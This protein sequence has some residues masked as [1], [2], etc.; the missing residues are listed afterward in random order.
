MVV[1]QK[2][3]APRADTGRA[4]DLYRRETVERIIESAE[5]ILKRVLGEATAREVL[6]KAQPQQQ[7][8]FTTIMNWLR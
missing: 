6:S 4:A 5:E 8:L 7:S 2:T 1:G 3:I